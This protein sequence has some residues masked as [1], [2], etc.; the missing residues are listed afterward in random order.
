[1]VK[2]INR[3]GLFCHP[4][5][6]SNPQLIDQ[7]VN[8][9]SQHG[10]KIVMD[11]EEAKKVGHSNLGSPRELVHELI[12]MAVV[13][14]GDGSI[15]KAVREFAEYSI[16]VAGINLGRLGFLTMGSVGNTFKILEKLRTGRYNLEDRMMLAAT[17]TRNG[18]QVFQR[19][20]LNDVV[21]KNTVAGVISLDVS[22]SGTEVSSFCGDGVIFS[23]PTGS[24]AY[25]LSVGG[26]IVPPWM[27]ILLICPISSHTLGTRPVITSDHEKITAIL[28]ARFFSKV[29]IFTDGQ[30]SFFVEDGDQIQVCKGKNI[31]KIVVTHRR[32]FFKVLRTKMKWGK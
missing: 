22:I 7:I 31:A 12:D 9:A 27:S 16:P 8:W 23:S 25:S 18:K 29:S 15:L 5:N 14:G 13:L 2:E 30:D 3:I 28:R 1:M 6:F 17:I 19:T 4:T 11:R 26:P 24:T 20:A 32:N 10:V 21:I